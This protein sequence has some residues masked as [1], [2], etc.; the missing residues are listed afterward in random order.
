M[1]L[2]V[3]WRVKGI[4]PDARETAR[5]AARRS[6]MSV[7]EWLNT[8]I[9]DSAEEEGVRP[10]RAYDDEADDDA[11]FG[12]HERLDELPRQIERL[13]RSEA[14]P[15][16]RAQRRHDDADTESLAAAIARLDRRLDQL[17]Q[18]YSAPSEGTE[19]RARAASD[20]WA[21][22]MDEA[23]AEITARQQALDADPG[24]ARP[25]PPGRMPT[26]NLSGLEQQL[27]HITVQIEA[28]RRPSGLE[29]GVAEL[30]GALGEIARTLTEAMPRRAIESLEAEVRALA[31]RLDSSR[32]SGADAAT[33]ANVE[34][35]LVDIRDT[36]RALTPAENLDGFREA[37]VNLSQKI[38]IL[39]ASGPNPSAFQQLEAAITAL[40]GIASHVASNDAIAQLTA[41]V[42]NIAAK[43]DQVA[44][45]SGAQALDVLEKRIAHIAEAL[46][47]RAREGGSVPPQLDALIK[48]LSNKIERIQMNGGDQVAF[49]QFEDRIVKLVE[50]LDAS[51]ARFGQLEA[52]ERGL[53]D[54]LVHM[55]AQRASGG[56]AGAPGNAD[57]LQRDLAR[58]QTSL[59][60]VHGAL[61]HVVDRLAMLESGMR[62]PAQPKLPQ[63][64]SMP[65]PRPA[66]SGQQ[67]PPPERAAAA[68]QAAAAMARANPRTRQPIDPNLPPDQPLEPGSGAGRGRLSASPADRIAASQAALESAKPPVIPDPGGKSNFIAAARRA[69]QA[70]AAD[71]SPADL[72]AAAAHQDEP[73]EAPNKTLTQRVRSLFVGAGV[74]LL[75]GASLRI[76]AN[77]IQSQDITGSTPQ[78]SQTQANQSPRDTQSP[79]SAEAAKTAPET[80]AEN[81]AT[82]ESFSE[83]TGSLQK[84]PQPSM[85]LPPNLTLPSLSGGRALG[86]RDQLP[87]GI[88][89]PALRTAAAAGNAVAQYEVGIRYAEG[90]GVAANAA[91]AARWLERAAKQGVALA[92]FRLA[93]LYEKGTGV[94]KDVETA[95]RLYKSAAE[96][97]NAKAM[98]NLAVLYAEGAAVKPDYRTAAQWFRLASDHG[99]SDS[100]YN[101]AILYARGIGVDR[102]LAES[103][104]WFAIAAAQGD[105][106]A[107]LKRDDVAKHLDVK[108]LS[109]AKRAVRDFVP[110]PQPDAATVAEPPSGG[111]DAAS[112]DPASPALRSKSRASG[113]MRLGSR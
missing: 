70:A 1:K 44:T 6:G 21:G 22:G 43:I 81:T 78:P 84:Q 48:G 54:L 36:L 53:A 2:G 74:I 67:P 31:G 8:V 105:Q 16:R 99:I 9:L 83:I 82:D 12:V 109:E 93:G 91:E 33:L 95:R 25:A 89:G 111:W 55:E 45:S 76:G 38:D 39:S 94:K 17:T 80:G 59:E 51:G 34:R 97:G 26:Q 103:Y 27:R 85:S 49:G 64:A 13:T 37:V 28:L 14:P 56:A 23:I 107:A 4:R 72:R 108:S 18:G 77:L 46:E 40:R 68:A 106:D 110:Q 63:A 32:N 66:A 10:S 88:G 57:V 100:Q 102:N 87:A 69:A 29:E 86:N 61:G 35:G 92:Q 62:A 47:A 101:L 113:P 71:P 73:E 98:H 60:A 50:K 15:P 112:S 20:P 75:I 24:A 19:Q 58:T 7:G 79:V 52:I 90:R 5:E 42:H 41:E 65:A 96:Q 104:K 3:P 30:R 11:S